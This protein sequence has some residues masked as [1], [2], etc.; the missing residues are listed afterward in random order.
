MTL[1]LAVALTNALAA[2]PPSSPVCE[3]PPEVFLADVAERGDQDSYL[4]L[5]TEDR[6]HD[7]LVAAILATPVEEDRA[8]PR[9]TRA[10]ALA[11]ANRPTEPWKPAEVRLLA[12]SDRR[13]LADAVKAHRGRRSASDENDAIFKLQPWYRVDPSYSDNVLTPVELE[14]IAMANSPPPETPPDPPLTAPV[15]QPAE[16]PAEAP[17]AACSCGTSSPTAAWALGFV[18]VAVA[19]RRRRG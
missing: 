19:R 18:V 16:A 2:D 12:P 3:G 1:L 14:N 11:L 10:L 6:F 13:L 15:M 7:A 9:Y 17:P 4:C 8:R 5:I